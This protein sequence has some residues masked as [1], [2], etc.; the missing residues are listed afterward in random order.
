MSWY[1]VIDFIKG[2]TG[3]VLV[4]AALFLVIFVLIARH[5]TRKTREAEIVDTTLARLPA[6]QWWGDSSQPQETQPNDFSVTDRKEGFEPYLPPVLKPDPPVPAP[7][8]ET[9]DVKPDVP[10]EPL[11]LSQR[12]LEDGESHAED[13]PTESPPAALAVE[14][15]DL[16][17]CQL[18]S[19]VTSEQ[20]AAPVQA[21]VT[22]PLI[23]RGRV[24]IP[25][26]T[27]LSGSI[28]S[29][30]G[31]RMRFDEKW[32]VEWPLG[33][34]AKISG[35]VQEASFDP[36]SRQYLASDGSAGIPARIIVPPEKEDHA[37]KK[38]LGTFASAAGRMSQERTRTAIGD[39]IPASARNVLLEGV[40]DLV[41]D[42]TE[43]LTAIPT[44]SH[45]KPHAEIQS[46]TG[47]YIEVHAPN[48]A[49][50]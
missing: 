48:G 29:V 3:R 19:R 15:G 22:A 24:I 42:Q 45:P 41:D 23:R 16:L 5:H 44:E 1:S 27:K 9:P 8:P 49:G 40:S 18:L 17:H 32:S 37:W 28:R 14:D 33:D 30:E 21:R 35:D 46:G 26:G 36:A 2:R 25:V 39:Q 50:N 31:G 4:F 38:I 43:A 20:L 12:A 34:R 10:L 7:A 47:F 6:A 13:R 11:I